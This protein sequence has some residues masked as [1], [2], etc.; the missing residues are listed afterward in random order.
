[1]NVNHIYI[2]TRLL[3]R[4][5]A[6]GPVLDVSPSVDLYSLGKVIFYMLSGVWAKFKGRQM[7]RPTAALHASSLASFVAP[8]L[9]RGI[10]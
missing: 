4:C 8:D 10:I 7:D 1:V 3:S 6:L 9:S 2:N 5:Q